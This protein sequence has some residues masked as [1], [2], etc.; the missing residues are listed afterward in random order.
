MVEI[1][2]MVLSERWDL[3]KR[4]ELYALDGREYEGDKFREDLYEK[5]GVN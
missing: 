3:K 1:S 5:H 2:E 4:E